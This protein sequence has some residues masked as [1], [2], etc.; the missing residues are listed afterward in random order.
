MQR[1]ANYLMRTLRHSWLRSQGASIG[2]DVKTY[3]K[4]FEGDPKALTIGDKTRISRGTTLVAPHIDAELKI[5]ERCFINRNVTIDCHSGIE[6]GD[7]VAIGPGVYIGDFDHS[8]PHLGDGGMYGARLPVKIGSNSWIGANVCILKGVIIGKRV[9]V[10][11][12]SV[13]TN[14]LANNEVAV[15]VPAR[16]VKHETGL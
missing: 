12:G 4:F 11:A 9:A 5:G 14:S 10:G 15:G 8:K 13:V 7:E 1:Y 16:P 3:G 6:I 2:K